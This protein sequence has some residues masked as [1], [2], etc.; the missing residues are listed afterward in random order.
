[1]TLTQNGKILKIMG[2]HESLFSDFGDR[3]RP[4][5]LTLEGPSFL[6]ENTENALIPRKLDESNN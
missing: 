1:M 3:S 2:P 4:L 5:S 6:E